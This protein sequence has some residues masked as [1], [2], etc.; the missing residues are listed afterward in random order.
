MFQGLGWFRNSP[1]R[2]L[3]VLSWRK[4]V[5]KPVTQLGQPFILILYTSLLCNTLLNALEM[6]RHSIDTTI[7]G[8]VSQIVLTYLVMSQRAVIVDLFSLPPIYVLSRRLLSSASLDI[9]PVIIF[10]RALVRVFSSA[11][12][13]YAFGIVQFGFY[14]F[15]RTT[16]M[17]CFRSLG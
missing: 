2:R 3:V 6:S 17:E 9:L 14:G 16:V 15:L 4:L 12:G 11:I 13:L 10:S 7:L 1:I 8:F 5:I